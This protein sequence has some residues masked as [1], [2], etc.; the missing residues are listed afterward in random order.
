MFLRMFARFFSF[1]I[2]FLGTFHFLSLLTWPELIP[3]GTVEE[4]GCAFG[5]ELTQ[6][7]ELEGQR[8]P[9]QEHCYAREVDVR[10]NGDVKLSELS[11]L[12]QICCRLA[13]RSGCLAQV[14]DGPHDREEICTAADDIHQMQNIMP[15]KP[16]LRAGCGFLHDHH[17][18]VI[19]D[20][21]GKD[22]RDYLFLS[23]CEVGL[24]H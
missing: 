24:Q 23:T 6:P 18:Y 12:V 14:A 9:E 19:Q 10:D 11:E 17:R 5:E 4:D 1:F 15:R 16:A 22:K 3:G 13:I 2:S 21:K 7:A 8:G 20:L